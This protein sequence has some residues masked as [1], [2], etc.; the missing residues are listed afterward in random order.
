M[1]SRTLAIPSGDVRVFV[2]SRS[3]LGTQATAF[4]F[5]GTATAIE[6]I[7]EVMGSP[8]VN[9]SVV[10]YVE[11]EYQPISDAGGYYTRSHIMISGADPDYAHTLYHE[12]AHHY[13]GGP[14]W[15]AEGGAQFLAAYTLHSSGGQDLRSRYAE[16]HGY[17]SEGVVCPPNI[18]ERNLII[19]NWTWAQWFSNRG[20]DY[21]LGERFLIALYLEL[22][23]EMAAGS[24]RELD[25]MWRDYEPMTEEAIYQ[26]LLSHTPPGREGQFQELYH[27]LH[28]RPTGYEPPPTATPQ[29]V[30]TDRAALEALYNATRRPQLD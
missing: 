27:R 22:G 13:I 30:E 25:R 15:L 11:P 29:S 17:L 19:R 14:K 7:E 16:L 28:G 1:R 10:L 21:G 24:L 23:H 2:V 26:V 9:P 5:D 12:L 6:A 3:P 8:W 18:H 20:C 4:L